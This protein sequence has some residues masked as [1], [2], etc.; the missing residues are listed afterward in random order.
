MGFNTNGLTEWAD[1]ISS[2]L[3][4]EVLLNADTIAGDL[5]T[6]KYG[7]IGDSTKLNRVGTTAY[8]VLAQCA[9]IANT[10]S[11]SLSQTEMLHCGIE[12]PQFLCND[13]LKDFWTDWENE[14]SFNSESLGRYED[15]MLA[16]ILEADRIALDKMIWQGDNSTVPYKAGLTGNNTLCRGFLGTAYAYSSTT[17]A[18]VTKTAMTNSNAGTVIQTVMASIPEVVAD[19]ALAYV[20]P[21][22]FQKVIAWAVNEYKYNATLFDIQNISEFRFP[23]SLGLTIKKTNGLSGADSGTMIVT[24][25]ENIVIGI[26]AEEDLGLNVWYEKKDRGLWVNLKVKVGTGY[27][28]P[29]LVVLVK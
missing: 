12:F 20:S 7:V 22:D 25:K 10:G 4:K 1:E 13:Q 24:P 5:V 2:G 26:S 28:F 15:V 27:Y 21:L 17:A 11:T 8:A 3:A 9:T 23:T 29:E 16:N 14:R 19:K 18:N 6:K